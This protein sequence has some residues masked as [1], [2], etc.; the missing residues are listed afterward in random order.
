M[1]VFQ[2]IY[3]DGVHTSPSKALRLPPLK[4]GREEREGQPVLLREITRQIAGFTGYKKVL[5]P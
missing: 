3:H 5:F 1:P 4:R 2:A